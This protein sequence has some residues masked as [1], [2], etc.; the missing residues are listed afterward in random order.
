MT[1]EERKPKQES[2]HQQIR[3][4]QHGGEREAKEHQ[5]KRQPLH[6]AAES[7]QF[8]CHETLSRPATFT[9]GLCAVARTAAT[10]GTWIPPMS[11][12]PLFPL[13]SSLFICTR[14]A[15]LTTWSEDNECANENETSCPKPFPCTCS[16]SLA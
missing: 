13:S 1:T 12:A 7:F 5:G 9:A 14:G 10:C 16:W 15:P 2:L 4:S 8:S 11:A 6:P 3:Y